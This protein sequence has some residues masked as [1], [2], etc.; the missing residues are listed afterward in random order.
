ME[1]DLSL[2]KHF[3]EMLTQC[4][5]CFTYDLTAKYVSHGVLDNFTFLVAIVT[6]EFRE[7][8]EAKINC[9][10]VRACCGVREI[11]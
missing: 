1:V 5:N 3:T 9:Y 2:L 10:L 7:V 4:F 11:L 6:R 8:L